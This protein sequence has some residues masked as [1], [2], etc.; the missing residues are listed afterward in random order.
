[1]TG[2]PYGDAIKEILFKP[3]GLDHMSSGAPNG[4]DI[5]AIDRR[6]VDNSSSWGGNPEF[7]AGYVTY[8]NLKDSN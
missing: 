5:D 7:V 6:P 1:M 8:Q 3:L 4:S 2:K